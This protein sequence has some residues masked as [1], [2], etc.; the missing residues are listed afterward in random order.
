MS[1]LYEIVLFS[2]DDSMLLETLIPSIDPRQQFIHGYF[3]NECMVLSHGK[4]IK[5]LKYLNRDLR[6]IIVIDKN[7]EVVPKSKD[8]VVVLSTFKGDETDREL[9]HLTSLLQS[10]N[11]LKK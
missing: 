6:N 4:Y 11:N 3:G 10:N 5:D 2:D 7:K 1:Q 8:N 9:Y